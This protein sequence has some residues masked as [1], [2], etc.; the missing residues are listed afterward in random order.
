MGLRAARLAASPRLQRVLALLQDGAPHTTRDIVR[1]AKVCAVN[2]CIAE[3]RDNG[4]RIACE[5]RKNTWRYWL[6]S[7]GRQ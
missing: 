4:Y 5:R 7:H 6:T 2:S 3:L 1:R